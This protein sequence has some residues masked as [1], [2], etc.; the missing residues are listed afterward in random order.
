M[1][2]PSP[3]RPPTTHR[4][5]PVTRDTETTPPAAASASPAVAEKR[6]LG[7]RAQCPSAAPAPQYNC[8]RCRGRRPQLTTA[9]VC[10]RPVGGGGHRRCTGRGGRGGRRS[11]RA[12]APAFGGSPRGGRPA[13]P[14][15][16]RP[17]PLSHRTRGRSRPG[18]PPHPAFSRRGGGGRGGAGGCGGGSAVEVTGCDG[19][20]RDGRRTH[21]PTSVDL[22]RTRKTERHR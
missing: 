22:R 1:G 2:P 18:R 4:A 8:C 21:A 6:E 20:C 10:H 3:Q 13:T 12:V 16:R 5:R 14:H 9:A 17:P 19:R 11:R 7:W 15:P